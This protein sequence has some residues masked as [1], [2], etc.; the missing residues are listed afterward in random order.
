[1]EHPGVEIRLTV[2]APS[3]PVGSTSEG[4]QI[5]VWRLAVT[6]STGLTTAMM[7]GGAAAGVG[8]WGGG[9]RVLRIGRIGVMIDFS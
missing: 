9:G 1:V 4:E 7:V 8:T 5:A 2:T 3:D 6:P